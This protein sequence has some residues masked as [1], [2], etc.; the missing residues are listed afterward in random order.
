MATVKALKVEK[1]VFILP[2]TFSG[3][4]ADALF[5][6]SEYMRKKRGEQIDGPADPRQSTRKATAQILDGGGR[7]SA[8]MSI[9]KLSVPDQLLK[10]RPGETQGV[11]VPSI[12][13]PET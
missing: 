7:L 11:I 6:A 4:E 9:H 2:D 12:V 3:D 10:G 8:V 1:L 13:T 5:L